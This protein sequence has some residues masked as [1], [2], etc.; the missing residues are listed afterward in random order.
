MK[1]PPSQKMQDEI[2]VV[3][4]IMFAIVAF[5][6]LFADALVAMFTGRAP[7]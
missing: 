2:G 3:V 5:N 7:T 4:L 1:W 6:L